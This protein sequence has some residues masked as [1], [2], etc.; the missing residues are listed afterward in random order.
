M[1]SRVALIFT[2]VLGVLAAGCSSGGDGRA[3][4]P[5]TTHAVATNEEADVEAALRRAAREAMN[6]NYRL[7]VYVLWHNRLPTWAERSTRGPALAALREAAADRR[8]EGI[9]IRSL[10][11]DY[12]IV[13]LE[14]DP[15]YA[16]ANAVVHDQGRVVPYRGG[17]KL[18]NAVA[19]NERARVE[20]RRVGDSPRF[21]VW[22]VTPLK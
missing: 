13:S 21:V 4:P 17:R 8:R 14:L 3:T 22:R 18:G 7:S 16:R 10:S 9:Q 11:G 5:A 20:L 12:R 19:I 2:L 1:T 15:S 6:E